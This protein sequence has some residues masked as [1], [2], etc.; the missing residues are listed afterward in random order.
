MGKEQWKDPQANILSSKPL[1]LF[2]D[3]LTL[4]VA[5]DI[6]RKNKNSDHTFSK[7]RFLILYTHM[8]VITRKCAYQGG[9]NVRTLCTY[10][11]H[12]WFHG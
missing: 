7:K 1:I 4:L 12:G 5:T 2:K 10:W 3:A 6:N 11:F 9:R 8:R